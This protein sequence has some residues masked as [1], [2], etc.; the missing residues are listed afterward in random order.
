MKRSKVNRIGAR[1]RPVSDVIVQLSLPSGVTRSGVK[2]TACGL[3]YVGD[4]LGKISA[5]SF[6]QARRDLLSGKSADHVQCW[7]QRDCHTDNMKS[8]SVGDGPLRK[9]QQAFFRSHRVHR[10]RGMIGDFL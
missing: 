6:F 2:K 9:W 8:G 7:E 10:V 5:S 1:R 3:M 4:L